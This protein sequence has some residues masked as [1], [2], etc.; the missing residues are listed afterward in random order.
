MDLTLRDNYFF[1]K[2]MSR[3]MRKGWKGSQA[4]IPM[5]YQKGV[6]TVAFNG[7]DLL[8]ITQQPQ[9]VNMTFYPTFSRI[10]D[11]VKFLLIYGETPNC[12]FA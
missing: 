1:G 7:F 4:V 8:P 6:P 9:T 5:K 2:V 12:A 11:V 10:V 3:E